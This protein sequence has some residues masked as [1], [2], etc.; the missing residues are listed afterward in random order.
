MS[1]PL[2]F[3]TEIYLC[4]HLC[5]VVVRV[6]GYKSIGLGLIPGT[7]RFSENYWVWKGVHSAS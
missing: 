5:G 3:V 7:A 2:D 6:P 4:D 1:K